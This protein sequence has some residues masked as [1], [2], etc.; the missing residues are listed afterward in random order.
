MSLLDGKRGAIFGVGN[1]NSLAW[2]IA[3]VAD[4]A[5]ARLALSYLNES[6]E[7]RLRPLAAQLKDPLLLPCDLTDDPQVAEF[8]R[9]LQEQWGSLDF[10]V[11]S[12]AFAEREDLRG[13]FSTTSKQGFV[14]AMVGS[15]YTLL[16]AV[17]CGL[18]LLADGGS[19]LTLTYAGSQRVFPSYGIMGPAKAALEASVRYLAAE[20]GGRG[21]R[22]NAISSGPVS[23]LSARGIHGFTDFM[24][25]ARQRAP[26]GRTNTQ[27][28]VGEAALWLLSDLSRAT[29]GHLIYVDC[30][31]FVMGV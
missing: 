29:T 31:D 23:T 8:Y 13:S 14:T 4:R 15:V 30:G 12:V 5:G 6:F 3:Q 16:S 10:I 7:R 28:E 20:L 21:I 11:H 2:G 17:R 24:G 25:A 27:E 22:V 9:Q 1:E 26:L 19:V 18:P